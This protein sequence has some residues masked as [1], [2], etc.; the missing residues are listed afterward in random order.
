MINNLKATKRETKTAGE[1]KSLRL[2]GL[3][4]AILYGG[5]S[6]NLKISVEEKS[7]NNMFNSEKFLSVHFFALAIPSYQAVILPLKPLGALF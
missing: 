2:K 5:Q 6:P 1:T 4:P 3:I 7:F